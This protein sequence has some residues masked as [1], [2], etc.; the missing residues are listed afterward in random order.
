MRLQGLVVV[1]QHLVVAHLVNKQ[2]DLSDL[3]ESGAEILSGDGSFDK[4]ASHLILSKLL[5]LQKSIELTRFDPHHL[6]AV[7]Y[8][9]DERSVGLFGVESISCQE[10][11]L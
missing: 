6:V 9:K 7:L 1:H 4:L 5:V 2:T 10:N 3:L 11:T 8:V